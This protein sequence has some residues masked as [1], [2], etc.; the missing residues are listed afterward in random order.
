VDRLWL[1]FLST[2]R[3]GSVRATAGQAMLNL[4]A[5]CAIERAAA[6]GQAA[7]LDQEHS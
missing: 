5:T 2:G 3:G 1:D 4:K 7:R 6:T